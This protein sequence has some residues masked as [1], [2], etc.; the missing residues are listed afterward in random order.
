MV[1]QVRK[2]QCEKRGS[3]G[4]M[5]LRSEPVS[6]AESEQCILQGEAIQVLEEGKI[7]QT[8]TV[9]VVGNPQAAGLA[10]HTLES[11]FCQS[12]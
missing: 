11:G 6:H 5:N 9:T 2:K 7:R 1:L 8:R 4:G 12:L 3:K 10:D